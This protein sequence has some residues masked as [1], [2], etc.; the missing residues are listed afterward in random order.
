MG[1]RAELCGDRDR[2]LQLAFGA[3]YRWSA[4]AELTSSKSTAEPD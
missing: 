2:L 4:P 1:V 3:G